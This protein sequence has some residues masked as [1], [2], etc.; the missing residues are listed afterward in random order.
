MLFLDIDAVLRHP[1][2]TVRWNG[3]SS[4]RS[5]MVGAALLSKDGGTF[6]ARHVLPLHHARGG[7]TVTPV[8]APPP[9]AVHRSLLAEFCGVLV[10]R[11]VLDGLPDDNEEA[12]LE[13]ARRRAN[14]IVDSLRSAARLADDLLGALERCRDSWLADSRAGQE[15]ISALQHSVIAGANAYFGGMDRAARDRWFEGLHADFADRALSEFVFESAPRNLCRDVDS[16]AASTARLRE[17]VS[18]AV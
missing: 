2:P 9:G 12:L 8:S 4:R 5:D 13:V 6:I 17:G 14:R 18:N 3:V 11:Q 7:E 15:A 1:Y 10:A 16:G